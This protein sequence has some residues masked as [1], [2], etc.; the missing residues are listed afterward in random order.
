MDIQ[1]RIRALE[2]TRNQEIER[3]N[4]GYKVQLYSL[5]TSHLEKSRAALT[6]RSREYGNV[7]LGKKS[8]FKA[9]DILVMGS[10]IDSPRPQT[11]L[12][13]PA[14]QGSRAGDPEDYLVNQVKAIALQTCY[15]LGNPVQVSSI[16]FAHWAIE[17]ASWRDMEQIL[18][19]YAENN[20]VIK[21]SGLRIN[22][23]N[24]NNLSELELTEFEPAQ[25]PHA[26]EDPLL[27]GEDFKARW[28]YDAAGAQSQITSG[29][30]FGEKNNKYVMRN[31]KKVAAI[32]LSIVIFNIEA[33]F[34]VP[35][36]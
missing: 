12:I 7:L 9:L 19:G 34:W 23:A 29:K 18:N 28:G 26:E 21:A 8:R 11:A 3:A 15:E 27:T 17:R 14:K 31:G 22:T 35:K 1:E 36:K 25:A 24:V 32:P 30:W 2:E 6:E 33:G 10:I 16:G 13:L 4:S 5:V 20:P